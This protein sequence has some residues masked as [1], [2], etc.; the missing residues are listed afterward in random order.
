MKLDQAVKWRDD[1]VADGWLIEPTYQTEDVSR[2][3]TLH[4]DGFT[5]QVITR[6]YDEEYIKT[7]QPWMKHMAGKTDVSIAVWG[8][9]TLAIRP[10]VAYS[11]EA[12]WKALMTCLECGRE[13]VKTQRV[14][15]AGRCCETCLP[16]ARKRDEYPGWTN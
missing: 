11:W 12:L 14:G 6:I 16:A 9:D 13:D 2:A 7:A 15:F 3:A 8:P 10:G 4:K 5:A 1:A